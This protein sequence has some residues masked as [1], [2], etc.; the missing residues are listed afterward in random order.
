MTE[1]RKIVV[2]DAYTLCADELNYDA[3]N[4]LGSVTVYE[5]TT[6]EQAIERIGDA[7]IIL[8]NKVVITR[9]I[10]EACPSLRYV[11]VT[12]TGF[13]IVDIE[14]A[15][16]RGI[17][18]TNAPAYSTQAVAQHTAAFLLESLNH[19]A[20]YDE[21]VHDGAWQRSKDFCFLSAKMEEAAG[22]TMGLIGFGNIGQSVAKIALALGMRVL[23]HVPHPKEG[24]DDVRFVS[25]DELVSES[26][27]I[28]LHCP[29]KDENKG[30][31]G[32]RAIAK[33]KTGVR[34]INTARGP[35]VDERAMADALEAGKVACYMA[36]V[37]SEEPPKEDNPLLHAPN[38]ILTPHVAWAPLQTRERLLNIVVNNVCAYASGNPVNVV[39]R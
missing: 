7:E 19:V 39:S 22:K 4:E 17:V 36:D 8:T 11:G 25:F 34:V 33:M 30:M 26:D 9:E 35:L 2:L 14:E 12:A 16:R 15:K 37:L 24:W 3:L 20:A 27:I 32:E 18:V 28:S 13:N 6:P 29:L 5:R 1:Q 31:I 21:Q 23:V 38:A 10:M